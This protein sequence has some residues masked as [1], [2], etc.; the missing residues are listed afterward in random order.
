MVQIIVCSYPCKEK[1]IRYAS[2]RSIHPSMLKIFAALL[3][4]SSA[5][6]ATLELFK[7]RCT[8]VVTDYAGFDEVLQL[9]VE[10]LGLGIEVV[11]G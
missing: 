2:D 7:I 11:V 9:G 4:R 1:F 8:V 3:L 6:F 5:H 10:V